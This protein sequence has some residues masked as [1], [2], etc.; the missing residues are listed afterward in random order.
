MVFIGTAVRWSADEPSKILVAEK[1]GIIR[2]YNIEQEQPVLSLESD[3]FPLLDVD[4]SPNNHYKV[5]G[6]ARGYLLV[7]DTSKSGYTYFHL[8]AP[9]CFYMYVYV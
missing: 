1:K 2:L 9:C 7:W 3:I 6:I 4:W 5:A 8:M